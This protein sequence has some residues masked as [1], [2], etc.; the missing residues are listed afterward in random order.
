MG[1]DW[2]VCVSI[3]REHDCKYLVADIFNQDMK[4]RIS[5]RLP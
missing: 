2:S 4:K 3:L 5:V 1:V